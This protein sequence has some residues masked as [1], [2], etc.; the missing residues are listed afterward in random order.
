ML[1]YVE[2]IKTGDAYWESEIKDSYSRLQNFKRYTFKVPGYK[3]DAEL[4]AEWQ[5]RQTAKKGSTA[6]IRGRG[7]AV[8][9]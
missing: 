8:R 4:D 7:S 1:D 3:T 5:A 9:A 6:R 2:N